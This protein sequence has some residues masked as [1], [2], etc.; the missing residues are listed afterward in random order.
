MWRELQQGNFIAL[1]NLLENLRSSVHVVT[2]NEAARYL[3]NSAVGGVYE[4]ALS[5]FHT[6]TVSYRKS[7]WLWDGT[8]L[9]VPHSSYTPF[10]NGVAKNTV[11]SLS[12]LFFSY[13]GRY[14]QKGNISVL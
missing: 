13:Q 6:N 7:K 2:I 5:P 4:I 1:E 14:L 12:Q 11:H 9:L 3:E 10:N 8:P